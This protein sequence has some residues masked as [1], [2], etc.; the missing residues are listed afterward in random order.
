MKENNE[1]TATMVVSGY[2]EEES[3]RNRHY[4]LLYHA[5]CRMEWFLQV[6]S[7]SLFG[8]LLANHALGATIAKS[9]IRRRFWC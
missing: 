5:L 4:P 7:I 9:N 3:D 1:K 6:H 8:F 2:C